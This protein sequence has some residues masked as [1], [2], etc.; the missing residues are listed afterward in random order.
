MNVSGSAVGMRRRSPGMQAGTVLQ[1]PALERNPRGS[2]LQ[3][4][5]E[6]VDAVTSSRGEDNVRT[7]IDPQQACRQR[8]VELQHGFPT[9]ADLRA[10]VRM[11]QKARLN[12]AER[13]D[14]ERM[15]EEREQAL[16]E[17]EHVVAEV[18]DVDLSSLE[19]LQSAKARLS[20]AVA[21]AKE[22]GIAARDIKEAELRR[23]R[24]H[25]A[26]E[27]LKGSIRVFCRVRP[28]NRRELELRDACIAHAEDAMTLVVGAEPDRS[29][30]SF[31]GVFTPGSQE[32]VFES[33]C[34][35]VQSAVDGYN[36][37]MFAYGQTG[38]GKTFTMYGSLG[39]EGI[40]PRTIREVFRIADRD[41]D[42]SRC[43]VS[44]S[45]VEL[46]RN[47][48]VD[49]LAPRAVHR[50]QQPQAGGRLSVHVD[51]DKAVHVDHLT[52]EECQDP[53]ELLQLLE[54]GIRQRTVT[55]TAMNSQ[56]SRSHLLMMINILSTN[57]DSQEQLRGKILL[58]DLA[59]SERLK[60]SEVSGD[61]QKEAIEINRSLTA[62]GDVIEALT[63]GEKHIPYKNHKLTQLM[64]DALGGSS[65][66]L[67]IVNCSPA[68]A[69]LDETV[70]ALKYA[71][72][73]KHI[74]GDVRRHASRLSGHRSKAL[75][76][77]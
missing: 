16:D 31:D 44:A 40:A 50:S 10:A 75:A 56:S 70:G 30:F 11:A 69:D 8:L 26:L 76:C 4:W 15:L 49:L 22:L 73:A 20:E 47:E 77:G 63:K 3:A 61:A 66:T 59:G 27:N 39:L 54:R 74:P 7:P 51:R 35:L 48:L 68:T 18:H 32:E 14:V 33:C 38:A 42:R 37:T 57:K 72:R 25:N 58:C 71:T 67:M 21:C 29:S 1:R 5:E 55:A 60:R 65:K 62:L 36:V 6:G 34:D 19:E 12:A 43:Q 17:V 13:R 41:Q 9:L 2:V 23:R 64:Q 45:M 52:E 28:L 24:L 46:Y 53:A